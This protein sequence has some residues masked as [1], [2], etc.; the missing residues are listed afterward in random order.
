MLLRNKS[1]SQPGFTRARMT[2]DEKSVRRT[3]L[4]HQD[5]LVTMGGSRGLNDKSIE[6]RDQKVPFSVVRKGLVVRPSRVYA[7]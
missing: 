1:M 7:A 4:G 6:Q 5:S 3:T 2:K